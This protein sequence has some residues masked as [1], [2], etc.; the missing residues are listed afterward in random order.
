[1]AAIS[2]NLFTTLV[3]KLYDVFTAVRSYTYQLDNDPM[4]QSLND[5]LAGMGTVWTG[6]GKNATFYAD[7]AATNDPDAE[8]TMLQAAYNLDAFMGLGYSPDTVLR[9]SAELKALITAIENH[10]RRAGGEGAFTSPYL[11]NYLRYR[12]L[13]DTPVWPYGSP[14]IGVLTMVDDI[15]DV[16][17]GHRLQARAVPCP[18]QR[19][20]ATHTLKDINTGT[21]AGD[22]TFA[23]GQRLYSVFANSYSPSMQASAGAGSAYGSWENF[24]EAPL[25]ISQNSAAST[26]TGTLSVTGVNGSGQTVTVNYG[27]ITIPLTGSSLQL[28]DS[29]GFVS[30]TGMSFAATGTLST[31]RVL[32][33]KNQLPAN[34]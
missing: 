24:R 15:W 18:T 6:E 5:E 14:S 26:I 17:R 7:I 29:Y 8:L 21:A 28:S 22:W 34:Y 20:L 16:L 10:L 2:A 11:E 32:T 1:M 4:Y 30:V 31:I 33:L 12:D 3:G 9:N 19:T 27:S 25:E 23:T 13:D